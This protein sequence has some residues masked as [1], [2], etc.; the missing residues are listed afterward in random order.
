MPDSWPVVKVRVPIMSTPAAE[1]WASPMEVIWPLAP[2]SMR[3]SAEGSQVTM[4][5]HTVS[6]PA[7]LRVTLSKYTV[8]L[9]A[10]PMS[11]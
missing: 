11:S 4:Y 9:W 1:V 8:R 10:V 5:S 7:L 6:P 2:E 3:R